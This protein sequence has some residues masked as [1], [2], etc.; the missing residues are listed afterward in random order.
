ME[1]GARG[2]GVKHRTKRGGFIP[3]IDGL[4]MNHILAKKNLQVK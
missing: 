2:K 3:G 1:L 4:I